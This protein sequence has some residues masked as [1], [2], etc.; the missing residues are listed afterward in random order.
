MSLAFSE[1]ERGA[2]CLALFPFTQGFPLEVVVKAAESNLLAQ[3]DEHESIESVGQII[4]PGDPP[5]EVVS[6]LKLRRV[7]L[8]QDGTDSRAEDIIVASIRSIDEQRKAQRR[9]WYARL[10]SGQHPVQMILGAERRH[11]TGGREAFVNLLD[12]RPIR[13]AALLRR[14]GRLNESEMRDV[15]ERVVRALELDISGLFPGTGESRP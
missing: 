9:R 6:Q 10:A 13:K 15:S 4:G 1:M 8:L 7:L 12:I 14:T 3:L 2:V 5:L 11:G